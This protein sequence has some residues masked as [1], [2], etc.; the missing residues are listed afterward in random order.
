MGEEVN[1][2]LK[3]QGL[4]KAKKQMEK[5]KEKECMGM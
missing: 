4:N 2:E 5:K 3:I 1:A